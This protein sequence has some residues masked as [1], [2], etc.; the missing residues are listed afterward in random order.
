MQ[1]ARCFLSL[2]RTVREVGRM[3]VNVRAQSETPLKG[4]ISP[5]G[6]LPLLTRTPILPAPVPQT[7]VNSSKSLRVG[8]DYEKSDPLESRFFGF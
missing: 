6:E 1:G 8:G 4:T 3:D 7:Q 2:A 5:L